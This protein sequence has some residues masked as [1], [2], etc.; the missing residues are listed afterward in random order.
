MCRPP[1]TMRRARLRGVR[2]KVRGAVLSASATMPSSMRTVFS[3]RSTI[4][5]AP[6]KMSSTLSLIT[7]MPASERMRIEVA[8]SRSICSAVSSSNSG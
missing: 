4:A 3:S 1:S 5:P 7:L 8:C 2:V 6:A